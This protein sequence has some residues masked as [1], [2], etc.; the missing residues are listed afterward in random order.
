MIVGGVG[1]EHHCGFLACCPL[2][3]KSGVERLVVAGIGVGGDKTVILDVLHRDNVVVGE[4]VAGGE[5][6]VDLLTYEVVVEVD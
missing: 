4:G 1:V 3:E 5:V 6:E 2:E